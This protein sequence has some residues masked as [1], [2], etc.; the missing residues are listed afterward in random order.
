MTDNHK[1]GHL[2]HKEKE[3]HSD[4]Y[5]IPGRSG[6]TVPII[7]STSIPTTTTTT[8]PIIE[9]STLPSTS[10]IYAP[11]KESSEMPLTSTSGEI[12]EST[13]KPIT[14]TERPLT[15]TAIPQTAGYVTTAGQP[16]VKVYE[17]TT[18][19][20]H[21]NKKERKEAKAKK[22]KDKILG[23]IPNPFQNKD[24]E[25][26]LETQGATTT[27][28]THNVCATTHPS[29]RYETKRPVDEL[30]L[31]STIA[32]TTGLGATSTVLPGTSSYQTTPQ[33]L[34]QETGARIVDQPL[35]STSQPLIQGTGTKTTE[36]PLLGSQPL[37]GQKGEVIY[38]KTTTIQEHPK[39]KK[40]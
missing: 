7:E 5:V 37:A 31:A 9:S 18:I 20:H 16:Q 28:G 32:G 8:D 17:K 27:I 39:T 6:T 25:G 11:I 19:E 10:I 15:T 24:K 33:P 22:A 40:F 29:E 23:L 36:Q 14:T 38:T 3:V 35:T 1:H 12:I 2:R 21:D 13:T 4:S 34:I 26:T 30:P